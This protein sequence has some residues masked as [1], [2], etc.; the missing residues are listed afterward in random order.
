[1]LRRTMAFGPITAL[2][3]EEEMKA[4]ARMA[5][6]AAALAFV[7]GC[8]HSMRHTNQQIKDQVKL[9]SAPMI[10]PGTAAPSGAGIGSPAPLTRSA[11]TTSL[12]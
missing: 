10:E 1:M 8:S 2:M 4:I 11:P 9:P 7:S 3:E 12:P 5:A 6:M